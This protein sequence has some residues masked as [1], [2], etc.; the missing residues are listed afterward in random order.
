MSVSGGVSAWV[1]YLPE[2]GSAAQCVQAWLPFQAKWNVPQANR[3]CA[4]RV[5]CLLRGMDARMLSARKM[6]L[7][8]NLS[9]LGQAL[10]PMQTEICTPAELPAGVEML[11]NVY[12]AVLPVEAG[13]KQ[14]QFEE[15]L[16]VPDA[17]QWV[18][19]SLQPQVTEQNVIG[20]RIVLRGY[21][22]L[23]Y[24]YLDHQGQ[25]HAGS[26]QIPFAQFAELD[27]EY[28]D[29]QGDVILSVSALE[30]ETME[31]G[32]R[33]QCSILAQYL[34]K[35]RQLLEMGED[36]YSPNY[37]VTFGTDVLQLPME[38]DSRTETVEA[39][40]QFREGD[41]LDMT[42]FPE[43][44]VQYREGDCLCL[45]LPMQFRI[46]YRDIEGNLQSCTENWST[47]MTV[48]AADNTQLQAIIQSL[49]PSDH[50]ACITLNLQT[51]ANQNLPMISSLTIGERL[52]L[53]ETRPSLILRRM[54][55]DSLW[56][57]A[58]ASGS[59]MAAIRK[60]NQLTQDPQPGQMLL[61]PVI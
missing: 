40:S 37:S 60:A 25:L 38:L 14:F 12:P 35:Q 2:D 26:Q 23:R 27:R 21:G 53:D 56:N 1:L 49:E 31:G 47:T 10:E 18:N 43:H 61:I 46:L 17:A 51:W 4:M 13:E 20:G 39:V 3:E 9:I 41:V 34:I 32:M 22:L 36:A 57:L 54:D 33:V 44:P 48:P 16:H 29:A 30:P 42:V 5:S 50:T 45:E 55:S 19:F 7:R 11:T 28:E 15:E 8:A 6:L 59:T 24:L 52:A 58:K